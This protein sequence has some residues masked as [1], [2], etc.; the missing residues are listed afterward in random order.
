MGRPSGGI[1]FPLDIKDVIWQ[2]GGC[3]GIQHGVSDSGWSSLSYT[4]S[5]DQLCKCNKAL[6]A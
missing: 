3:Q 2:V 1:H 4:A 6:A 5:A